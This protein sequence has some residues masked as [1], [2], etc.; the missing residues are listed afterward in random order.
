MT[1][2][3]IILVPLVALLA[4]NANGQEPCSEGQLF[5][6]YT[7]VC[8]E[9][10]DMRNV[11]LPPE[12][13]PEPAEKHT[14]PNLD[15]LRAASPAPADDAP[16]PGTIVAGITYVGDAYSTTRTARLHT[17]M[18]VYPNGVQ[19]DQYLNWLMTPATNNTA[20]AVEVVGIY[21]SEQG[22]RGV[23]GV[24]GRPC[25]EAFPCPNGKVANS[26]QFFIDFSALACNIT[27]IVDDGG[28]AQRAMHYGNH[29]D[30]LD[31]GS[32][33][34]WQSSVYLWNYCDGAWDLAW[35]HRYRLDKSGIA[36][37]WW[38]PGYEIFGDAMYPPIMELGYEDSLLRDDDGWSVLPPERNGFID[39]DSRPERTPWQLFHRQPNRSFGAGSTV[40]DN[41]APEIRSQLPVVIDEDASITIRT[42]D[43]EIFDADVDPA[44]H[45]APAVTVFDGD[46]YLRDERTI[47]PDEDFF[48]TLTVPVA[49]N[50]G[51]ADSKT[52]DLAVEVAPVNDPPAILG[53]R[54]LATLER[55]PLTLT[56]DALDVDDPD[57]AL[58]ELDLAVFDGGDYERTDNTVT[59]LPGV[60]G[61]M[62]VSV[63][64]ADPEA[65]SDVFPLSVDVEADTIAPVITIIGDASISI[66]RGSTYNDAG[67][68][69]SDNLDGDITDRIVV[70]NPVDTTVAGTYSVIYDVSDLAGNSASAMRTVTVVAPPPP[71]SSDGGGGGGALKAGDVIGL[72]L[73][74][75]LAMPGR[76]L[77]D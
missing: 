9:V 30:R 55:S 26:W 77:A 64:V 74:L 7:G 46:N 18:F 60:V 61:T 67:A 69:A 27:H 12:P 73:L 11:F 76:R 3:T 16:V 68:T 40:N 48:G 21:R 32:P 43:L 54:P 36:P 14:I 35:Q 33:P 2:R 51:A 75:L 15:E 50:D 49:V 5:E 37:A 38:G 71:R 57:N 66:N 31:D 70:T 52:F 53:Q 8:A 24:F 58:D 34:L 72:T 4:A 47:T 28:H 23:L 63:A 13:E 20:K 44:Y 65:A 6:P 25:S 39:P 17:K 62:I 41:D 59:P 56:L 19:N 42:D 10:R 22:A 29:T 45:F 1:R